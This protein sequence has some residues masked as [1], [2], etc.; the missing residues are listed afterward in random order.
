MTALAKRI[1]DLMEVWERH[2]RKGKPSISIEPWDAGRIG[3]KM[4]L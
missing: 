3:Q 1:N 4:G 2:E